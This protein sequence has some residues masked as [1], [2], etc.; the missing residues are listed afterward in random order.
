MH[1]ACEVGEIWGFMLEPARTNIRMII[2]SVG[3]R[4][5]I[6][7]IS[8]DI[9]IIDKVRYFDNTV[10]NSIDDNDTIKR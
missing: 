6:L 2:S 7:H 8:F 10:D 3:N 1:A 4:I 5:E 9:Y